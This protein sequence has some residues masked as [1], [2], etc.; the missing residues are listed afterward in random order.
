MPSTVALAAA[1][2]SSAACRIDPCGFSTKAAKLGRGDALRIANGSPLLQTP[3][4]LAAISFSLC[5]QEPAVTNPMN[6]MRVRQ[7]RIACL[8]LL[9]YLPA[10]TSW[11]VGTPAPAEFVEREHPQ[12][13]RVTRTDGATL[14]LKA[15]A[16]R[17]DSLVGTVGQDS[18]VSLA[19]SE[20]RS[21]EAK[22]TD[23]GKTLLLIGAGGLVVVAVVYATAWISACGDEG[24]DVW[25]WW[26]S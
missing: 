2:A 7:S 24:A 21:V 22:R 4:G 16:V 13:V 10:C 11:Q 6:R 14:E 9:L 1:S 3:F 8:L 25:L 19:L 5:P 26:C 18:T 23:A 17:E 15:P 20:V 12:K